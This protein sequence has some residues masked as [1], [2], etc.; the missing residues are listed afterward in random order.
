L[1]AL[2][3]EY[4]RRHRQS[5]PIV[6]PFTSIGREQL[7]SVSPWCYE[8]VAKRF[9]LSGK[10]LCA[11]HTSGLLR[12]D[13]LVHAAQ[14]K[15][16]GDSDEEEDD[17]KGEVHLE[18]FRALGGSSS[19]EGPGS[20]RP[21]EA[22]QAHQEISSPIILVLERFDD[23][24]RYDAAGKLRGDRGC[25]F[26]KEV[27]PEIK[28]AA[29]VFSPSGFQNKAVL[30]YEV[31]NYRAA[32]D[33]LRSINNGTLTNSQGGRPVEQAHYMTSREWQHWSSG[34]RD[35]APLGW[36]ERLKSQQ[37]A[38]LRFVKR[39]E[40]EVAAR[41]REA[42]KS[43]QLQVQQ[44][45][46]AEEGDKSRQLQE[47]I[48]S[49]AQQHH[50]ENRLREREK[51]DREAQVQALVDKLDAQKQQ[52]RE[53]EKQHADTVAELKRAFQAKSEALA[54]EKLDTERRLGEA[55]ARQH[56]QAA[57]RRE[58]LERVANLVRAEQAQPSTGPV[59]C[60]L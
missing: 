32:D 36:F 28:V 33:M 25:L 17:F 47:H 57:T 35:G 55:E 59:S 6:C 30:V 31:R 34:G 41:T 50:E 10:A 18:L 8:H 21:V 37:C 19:S 42:D 7:K 44:A 23:P 54:R 22:S 58:D 9:G 5:A 53:R 4:L 46:L 24:S 43:R 11:G 3:E 51:Q 45:Q 16:S 49:Q 48:Q 27:Y 14:K 2:L 29:P 1:N 40:L 38:S 52:R 26:P 12:T 13:L 15:S 56:Q 39:S 20:R 60:T